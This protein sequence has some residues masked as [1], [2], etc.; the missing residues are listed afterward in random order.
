MFSES[1]SELAGVF[2]SHTVG[3]LQNTLISFSEHPGAHVQAV[4][5]APGIDGLS[6]HS[7]E[8][9]FHGGHANVKALR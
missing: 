7:P 2:I 4:L 5:P 1:V 8:T 9:V 6:I 3:D